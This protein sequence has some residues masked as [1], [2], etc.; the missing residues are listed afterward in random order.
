MRTLGANNEH[1]GAAIRNGDDCRFRIH[2][3]HMGLVTAGP[4]DEGWLSLAA[5]LDL[6]TKII[7]WTMHDYIHAEFAIA[8]LTMAVQK[9]KPRAGLIRHSDRGDQQAV[10]EYRQRIAAA[11]PQKEFAPIKTGLVHKTRFPAREA[12]KRELFAA[13][14]GYY[15]RQCALG[16]IAPE[17]PGEEPFKSGVH[18]IA[19][20]SVGQRHQ[21]KGAEAGS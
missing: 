6:C 12:V 9:Q 19:G 3:G 11:S 1:V 15:N 10:A 21:R 2:P 13:I 16:C 4:T 8:G 17:K 20:R 7:G 14:E 5:V 18:G